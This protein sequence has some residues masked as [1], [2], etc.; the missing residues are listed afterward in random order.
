MWFW[1]E[2]VRKPLMPFEEKYGLKGSVISAVDLLKGIGKFS[3]MNVVNVEGATGYID[4]NFEGKAQACIKELEAGQDFV[5][6]HV[7]APDECGHRYEIENKKRSIELIDEKILGPVLEAL[8][9]YDD[10]KVLVCP[11]HPTPLSLKTHTNDPIPF[12]IYHKKAEVSGVDTWNE[13]TSKE[14][15]LFVSEGYTLMDKFLSE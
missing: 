8:E 13:R 5:Y 10:Y 2:G 9:K 11:D 4:T 15:G 3:G 12:M 14:T 1:G 7:E 6:I